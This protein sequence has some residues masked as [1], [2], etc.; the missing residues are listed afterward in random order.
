MTIAM[1]SLAGIPGTVGFIGKFQLIHAL[2]DGSYTWLGIVLVFGS[3][4]S[5]GYYLRVVAAIWMSP[6]PS[7][8]PTPAAAVGSGPG[9]LAPMA[10]G[11][12]ETDG[13]PQWPPKAEG[14][15]DWSA[16]PA[17]AAPYPEVVVVAVLAG[18]ASIVFGIIPT[19]LFH[20]ASH[21]ASAIGGIF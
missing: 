6:S 12:P 20:L 5:L 1:L 18:A 4:V 17:K 3:M 15:P 8:T 10:G 2:V 13:D 9:G 21:A 14:H 16:E 11:S 19:P 7:I